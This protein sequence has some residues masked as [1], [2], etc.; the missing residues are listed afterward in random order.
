[1][2]EEW[3]ARLRDAWEAAPLRETFLEDMC[4]EISGARQYIRESDRPPFNF[5]GARSNYR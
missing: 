1:M 5:Y 2:T 3:A 4:K